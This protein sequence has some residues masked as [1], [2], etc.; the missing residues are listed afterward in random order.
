MGFDPAGDSL[1]LRPNLAGVRATR[2]GVPVLGSPSS[3]LLHPVEVVGSGVVLDPAEPGG[4]AERIARI[5]MT[6]AAELMGRRASEFQGSGRDAEVCL[7]SW[8]PPLR[9][10]SDSDR[11]VPGHAA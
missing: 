10:L 2:C 6:G 5:V 3:E 11:F 7:G 1:K 4:W 8:L 9:G